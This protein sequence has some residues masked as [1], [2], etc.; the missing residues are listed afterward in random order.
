MTD[1]SP[2]DTPH[3]APVKQFLD[4]VV[5]ELNSLAWL[6]PFNNGADRG[7]WDPG[8][9]CRD[10][11]VVLAALLTASGTHT[12]IIHGASVYLQGPTSAGEDPTGVGNALEQGGGH[13]WVNVPGFGTI[14]V[15]PRL[16]ARVQHWR[17]LHVTGLVG[18]EWPVSG[19]ASHVAIVDSAAAY[20]QAFAIA[21]NAVDTATAIYWPKQTEEFR[22]GMLDVSY[23]DSPLAHRMSEAAGPDCYLKLA[24]HLLRFAQGSRRRL[25]TVS[26]RKAWRFLNQVDQETI[27]ELTQ[28][29]AA[30]LAVQQGK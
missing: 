9:S 30:Q 18:S 7:R 15:S 28:A 4:G 23:I 22:A 27:G 2:V 20:Q 25:A 11:S 5:P 19:L 1:N 13:T 14:D 8:W 29:I 12:Q 26:Q 3:A 17:P 24:A 6:D 10:H 21:T 16:D